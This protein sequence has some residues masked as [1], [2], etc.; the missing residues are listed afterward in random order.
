MGGKELQQ[1]VRLRDT[2]HYELH[3]LLDNFESGGVS[4][5][6]GAPKS[7]EGY[8]RIWGR[9]NSKAIRDYASS[10]PAARNRIVD[11]LRRFYQENGFYDKLKDAFEAEADDFI[12]GF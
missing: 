4:P 6:Y 2:V 7:F 10:G 1:T 9:E 11:T 8:P 12:N 3:D 5:R